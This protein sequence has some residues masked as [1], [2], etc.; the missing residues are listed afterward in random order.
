MLHLNNHIKF[1]P[2]TVSNW[3]DFGTPKNLLNSH[4]EI[5]KSEKNKSNQFKNSIIHNPCYLAKDAIISDCEIG[6]NV[7]VGSGTKIKNSKIK[8]TIIQSNCTIEGAELDFSIIGN[9]VHY[10]A[11]FKSVNIGDYST[12]K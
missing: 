10:C 3:Y 11:K 5:L 7:S 6:P 9:N 12:F 1:T 2:H 8:N 4:A